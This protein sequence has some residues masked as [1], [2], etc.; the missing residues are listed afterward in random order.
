M[1]L[2]KCTEIV[3]MQLWTVEI[4][5][6]PGKEKRYVNPCAHIDFN[7]L[8]KYARD[9]NRLYGSKGTAKVV[10]HKDKEC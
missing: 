5:R 3:K 8:S 9:F 10:K 4:D 6:G 1:T 2:V 7:G